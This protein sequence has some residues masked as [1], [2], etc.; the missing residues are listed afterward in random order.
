MPKQISHYEPKGD[1]YNQKQKYA[2]S[3]QTKDDIKKNRKD[4]KKMK[5]MGM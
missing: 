4:A 3:K 5:A 2:I 1:I